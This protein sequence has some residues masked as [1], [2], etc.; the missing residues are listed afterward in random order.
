[1]KRA[2]SLTLCVIIVSTILTAC[3]NSKKLTNPE[4][5]IKAL[6][7][8]SLTKDSTT[9]EKIIGNWPEMQRDIPSAMNELSQSVVDAGGVKKMKILKV[10]PADMLKEA[11]DTLDN[12]T[13]NWAVVYMKS[14][15]SHYV[16][17]LQKIDGN[18]Y[19]VNGDDTNPAEFL[20]KP[21]KYEK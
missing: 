11:K 19:V 3:G 5:T 10:N 9:F 17:T 20:I 7:E 4:Q 1:M 13:N 14:S 2:I 21:D 15:K 8:A 16:W 12:R 6:Y 18:Y